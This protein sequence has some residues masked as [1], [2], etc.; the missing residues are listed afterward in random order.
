MSH[1]LERPPKAPG[2]KKRPKT[3]PPRWRTAGAAVGVARLLLEHG[4]ELAEAVTC[5]WPREELPTHEERLE[6][7]AKRIAQLDALLAEAQAEA[8]RAREAHSKAAERKVKTSAAFKQ[9]MTAAVRAVQASSQKKLS[10]SKQRVVR[11]GRYIFCTQ[12]W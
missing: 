12:G 5:D 10:A 2:P 9:E 7:H 8:A 6:M 1:Y 3:G 4:R 11:L